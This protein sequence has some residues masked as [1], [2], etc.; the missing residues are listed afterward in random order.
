MSKPTIQHLKTRGSHESEQQPFSRR[1]PLTSLEVWLTFLALE[2][3]ITELLIKSNEKLE[4]K[5]AW[6][7]VFHADWGR[8][9]FRL[10][11][12]QILLRNEKGFIFNELKVRDS[13]IQRT[14]QNAG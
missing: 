1:P 7:V 2:I 6:H 5:F 9:K 3:L 13:L 4:R 11:R 14:L 12:K 8:A 10:W